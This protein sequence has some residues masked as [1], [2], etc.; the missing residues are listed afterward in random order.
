VIRDSLLG[1]IHANPQRFRSLL[2]LSRASLY[3]VQPRAK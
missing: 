3:E 1:A 2:Q